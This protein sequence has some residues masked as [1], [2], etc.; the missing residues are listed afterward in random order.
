[1]YDGDMANVRHSVPAD[2]EAWETL[3]R[4]AQAT[5]RSLAAVAQQIVEEAAERLRWA[6]PKAIITPSV[7]DQSIPRAVGET[8]E[9][10]A[11]DYR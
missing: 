11:A 10:T 3:R 2:P 8:S 6:R 7:G 9:P 5:N 4:H 1:M